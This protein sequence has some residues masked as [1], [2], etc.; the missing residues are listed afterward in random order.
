MPM[1]NVDDELQRTVLAN[2]VKN[3]T[4]FVVAVANGAEFFG[5]EED[6]WGWNGSMTLHRVGVG[7]PEILQLLGEAIMEAI[8]SE[9]EG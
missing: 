3:E 4:T 1:T 7:S 8:R 9:M 5:D 6:R 2:V